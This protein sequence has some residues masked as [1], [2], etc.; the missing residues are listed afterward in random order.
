MHINVLTLNVLLS[1]RRAPLNRIPRV[2]SLLGV[3]CLLLRD[4]DERLQIARRT[5]ETRL[6]SLKIIQA[7]FDKGT[8]PELDV[9]QAQIELAIAQ[10]G[11][12]VYSGDDGL[13][14]QI[15][16]LGASGA[17]SVVSNLLPGTVVRTWESWRDGD[18]ATAWKLS[19]LLDP[20]A[21]KFNISVPEGL[22]S[23]APYVERIDVEF[24]ALPGRP[25]PATI[26][27]IGRE[28]ST[29]T[30]TYPVTLVMDPP[31]SPTLRRQPRQHRRYRHC[32]AVWP[33]PIWPA[34]RGVS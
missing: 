1:R 34:Y 10:S 8:V 4:L 16:G 14:F 13:N 23:Y 9:N 11:L 12:Q 28:A 27:E 30:R 2:S 26:L 18:I 17:V 20:T 32:C 19:R 7:R 25:V 22:I 33:A 24:D 29:S 15:Y 3:L 5:L 6:G 31:F 21:I